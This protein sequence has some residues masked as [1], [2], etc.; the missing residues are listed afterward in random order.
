MRYETKLGLG[1]R[2]PQRAAVVTA[3]GFWTAGLVLAGASA[4]RM[5]HDA[6]RDAG[7]EPPIWAAAA[8]SETLDDSA[9]PEGTLFLP[10]DVIEGH[11]TPRAGVMLM[12]KP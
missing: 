12:Q 2:F 10:M 9:E 8:P 1:G 11:G 4:L 6:A 7:N 5:H 3:L